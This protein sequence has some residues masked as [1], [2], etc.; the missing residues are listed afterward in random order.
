MPTAA[1]TTPYRQPGR[2][3]HYKRPQGAPRRRRSPHPLRKYRLFIW[4][5][6]LLVLGLMVYMG[7][8]LSRRDR[9]QE[10]AFPS[11]VLGVPVHTSLVAEGTEGR[12]GTKRPIKYIVIH[13]T[14]NHDENANAHAHAEFLTSGLSGTTSWHY[15]VDD[16][17]IYHHI[18]DDEIAWHAGDTADADGGNAKGVGIEL[19]VNDGSDFA[20]TR[21]NAAKLT[22]YLLHTY[23]LDMDAV[24]QHHD[25]SGKNCPQTMREQGLYEDFMAQTAAYLE[26]L[27]AQEKEK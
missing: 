15:T 7:I 8:W 4:L 27:K 12:P 11:E 20:A 26:Q 18:P 16:H 21:Q 14:A 17:E 5:A 22:A 10:G 1:P 2:K 13:E 25:C 23:G 3:V 9:Y 6:S 24:I 19:C